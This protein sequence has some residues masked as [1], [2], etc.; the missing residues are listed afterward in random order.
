MFKKFVHRK[1]DACDHVFPNAIAL[2]AQ[3]ST[4]ERK[5]KRAQKGAKEC[6][7]RCVPACVAKGRAVRPVLALVAAELG[8]ADPKICSKGL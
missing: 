6:K 8:A 3:M 1:K 7:S 4:K 5:R 2:D